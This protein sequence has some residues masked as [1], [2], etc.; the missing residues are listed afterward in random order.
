MLDTLR[1]IAL[2]KNSM[3]ILHELNADGKNIIIKGAAKSFEEVESLK[4]TL[5]SGFRGVKV[6]ESG[7]SADNKIIFTILMQDGTS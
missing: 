1:E 4:D 7:T 2:Q 3:I 5:T 6:I